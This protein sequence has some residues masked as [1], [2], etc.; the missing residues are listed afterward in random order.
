MNPSWLPLSI[1]QPNHHRVGLRPDGIVVV[2]RLST[3]FADAADME[4]ERQSMRV[5]LDQVGRK[6]RHLL[7]D[8]RLAPSRTDF[9]LREAFQQLR[10]E[11]QRSFVKTAVILQSKV[12]VLQATRLGRDDASTLRSDFFVT[13]NE[14]AA[15]EF[16]K[17]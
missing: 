16:L 6:G 9:E 8:S 4:A 5:A 7:V 12:G 11:I 1:Q 15:L 2:T 10:M 14:Q 13:D 3:Q 17:R